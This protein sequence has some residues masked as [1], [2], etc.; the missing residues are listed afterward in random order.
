MD[1]PECGSDYVKIK[2]VRSLPAGGSELGCLCMG[3]GNRFEVIDDGKSEILQDG[4]LFSFVLS[5]VRRY[6]RSL[7]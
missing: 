2:E 4:S 7:N 3:C 1:C 6:Q 5:R